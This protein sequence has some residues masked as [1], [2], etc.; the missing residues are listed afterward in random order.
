MKARAAL[1][2]VAAAATVCGAVAAAPSAASADAIPAGAAATSTGL[3]VTPGAGITASLTTDGAL[4]VITAPLVDPV[5]STASSTLL[6]ALVG[7]DSTPGLVSTLVS[8]LTSITGVSAGTPTT[9]VANPAPDFP[10]CTDPG[11]TST[12]CYSL[13]SVSTPAA[14][15]GV[16]DL[17]LPL[18][19]GYTDAD[20]DTEDNQPMIGRAQV[21]DPTLSLL[22]VAI[23]D[24]GVADS[25]STCPTADSSTSDSAATLSAE[26]SLT[27]ASLLGGAVAAHVADDTGTLMVSV[28]GAAAVAVS[29]LDTQTLTLANGLPVTV[30]SAGN[31][32]LGLTIHLGLA[33]LLGGLGLAAISGLTGLA[34]SIDLS[35]VLA[36]GGHTTSSD[37]SASA[38]GLQVKV[39][40]G[41]T[42]GLS[43]LGLIGAN[44]TVSAQSG[45]ATGDLLDLQ[46]ARTSCAGGPT[47]PAGSVWYPPGLI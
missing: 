46:L 23:G 38:A 14:T 7:N 5:L 13:A 1:A 18:V 21:T 24:L 16:I 29:E 19:H 31:N 39:G 42:L 30:G 36:P 37:G 28:A 11:W 27:G 44:L 15:S 32:G 6:A 8:A 4:S 34:G 9:Q 33:D 25:T 22:G 2:G 43:V 35:V 3:V 45:G 40:L 26:A 41:G 10:T 20:P 17:G 12:T 47:A